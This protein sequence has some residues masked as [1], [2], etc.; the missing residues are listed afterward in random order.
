ML[1]DST[2][3]LSPGNKKASSRWKAGRVAGKTRSIKAGGRAETFLR[4]S[5]YHTTPVRPN[6][7][8]TMSIF[9][10]KA[11]AALRTGLE[12]AADAIA[13]IAGGNGATGNYSLIETAY[14]GLQEE[15]E[16]F[17][18]HASPELFKR[19]GEVMVMLLNG[20]I[21]LI[22]TC[23]DSGKAKSKALADERDGIQATC[24]EWDSWSKQQLLTKNLKEARAVCAAD[25]RLKP[26]VQCWLWGLSETSLRNGTMGILIK[27]MPKR[28][29]WQVEVH[30]LTKTAHESVA[31]KPENLSFLSDPETC[32]ICM[33]VITTDHFVTTCLHHFHGACMKAATTDTWINDG[34]DMALHCPTC[35]K[36]VGCKTDLGFIKRDPM[37][38]VHGVMSHTYQVIA[39][40]IKFDD[41]AEAEA[42]M[43]A[44]W[45][46]NLAGNVGDTWEV[47]VRRM[48]DK[49][50]ANPTLATGKELCEYIYS[51]LELA[52]GKG[53]G[54]EYTRAASFLHTCLP[55]NAFD[56]A[57]GECRNW[58]ISLT[59]VYSPYLPVMGPDEHP[60]GLEWLCAQ[61]RAPPTPSAS[62][63][64]S[65]VEVADPMDDVKSLASD[66]SDMYIEYSKKVYTI[67]P[68]EVLLPDH[69][70]THH[71]GVDF[72]LPNNL[73]V[74][75]AP[76]S[77]RSVASTDVADEEVAAITGGRKPN[78]KKAKKD[79]KKKSVKQ[80]N[81]WFQKTGEDERVNPATG[82]K[83]IKGEIKIPPEV[84]QYAD[85][86]LL[87]M[88][89]TDELLLFQSILQRM[90]ETHEHRK[91]VEALVD[92]FSKGQVHM[93]AE[94]KSK[95]NTGL[96]GMRTEMKMRLG[97]QTIKPGEA[98]EYDPTFSKLQ[99]ELNN[100]ARRCGL[101]DWS[102]NVLKLEHVDEKTPGK[103]GELVVYF[104]MPMHVR[105]YVEGHV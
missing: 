54:S 105:K 100:L 28:E 33:D 58:L 15:Y 25:S 84:M 93:Q 63:A 83:D 13:E 18:A 82:K 39:Q 104:S 65:A 88:E 97:A 103:N 71:D 55:P 20:M 32:A 60:E 94:A 34:R 99:V 17:G 4:N 81:G 92:M 57:M 19:S 8:I 45:H 46:A 91:H 1:L 74:G 64:S 89:T 53:H 61:K 47:H 41:S 68:D 36:W 27:W 86:A 31:I 48:R 5:Q 10:G 72:T 12:D 78:P 98:F 102:D 3:T 11:D 76:S 73:S 42:A 40:E 95:M 22:D 7:P 14:Y 66:V 49:H 79:G 69:Y 24:V 87:G 96:S 56:R 9:P 101:A 26:G 62:S 44:Q 80:S 29:R 67:P 16:E 52:Y 23:T 30:N 2:V 75:P 38:L 43:C 50:L 6:L 90:P 70:H 59:G 37:E 77:S 51:L 85:P 21:A 35:R